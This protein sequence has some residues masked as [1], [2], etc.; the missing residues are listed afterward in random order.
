MGVT[1]EET[2]TTSVTRQTKRQHFVV[3]YFL[4]T[5]VK[6]LIDMEKETGNM[7][8][9]QHE[10]TTR[11][12]NP[13]NPIIFPSVTVLRQPNGIP[14]KAQIVLNMTQAKVLVKI[15]QKLQ[16]PI[17]ATIQNKHYRENPR[18]LSL[19]ESQDDKT[20]QLDFELQEFG[21]DSTHYR[22][23]KADI[24]QMQQY[25]VTR[26]TVYFNKIAGEEMEAEETMPLIAS[27]ILP[28]RYQRYLSLRIDKNVAELLINVGDKGYTKYWLEIAMSTSSKYTL[29]IYQLISS[30]VDKGGFSWTIKRFKEY[31]GIAEK[32]SNWNDLNARVIKPAYRELHEKANIWF[33]YNIE[34]KDGVPYKI[35]VEII[36]GYY[37]ILN[38]QD[39]TNEELI[40]IIDNTLLNERERECLSILRD[41][42][43]IN[44]RNILGEIVSKKIDDFF[45]WWGANAN[46]LS[47]LNSPSS[48]LLYHLQMT[49]K[50]G[51]QSQRW[52]FTDGEERHEK[53]A[54]IWGRICTNM[55]TDLDKS[56]VEKWFHPLTIQRIDYNNKGIEICIPN[57]LFYNTI[58]DKYLSEF[59][60]ALNHEFKMKIVPTYII[61]N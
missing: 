51:W 48:L 11:A 14:F 20:I 12:N 45:K 52:I 41:K 39:T 23:L 34:K 5:F 46:K 2:I 54:E 28:K 58:E 8:E 37:K 43:L 13:L 7:K 31:L 29:L 40:Q 32:Y 50:Q 57:G 18:Q 22:D 21:I 44:D 42:L 24:V 19:F 16:E 56:I 33:E 9:R 55:E 59:L 17:L 36:T 1:R 61:N 30:W 6:K 38:A 10:L 35:N 15:I 60:K 25:I 26:D 4:I 47:K 27:V 49:A 3:R 53:Y